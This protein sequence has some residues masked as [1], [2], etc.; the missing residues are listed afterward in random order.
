M[1]SVDLT[2]F[3]SY[4]NALGMTNS[5]CTGNCPSNSQVS[6]GGSVRSAV[7]L[8]PFG[9]HVNQRLSMVST[10]LHMP[11]LSSVLQQSGMER[12]KVKHFFHSITDVVLL[13]TT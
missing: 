2:L 8:E 1:L 13:M 11:A 7:C 10:N 12:T 9:K 5:A 3:D 4:G 6:C